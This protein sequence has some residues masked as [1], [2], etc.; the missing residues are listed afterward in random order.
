MSP[1]D[2]LP[3]L[4]DLAERAD[5]L[6]LERFRASDLRV[7][8]KPDRSLVTEADLA[9]EE[10]ARSVV[11]ERHPELGIFGEEHGEMVGDGLARLIIDPIDAT[12]NFA[13]GIPVFAT[14]LAIEEGDEVIAGLVSAPALA[15]RWWAA[16]GE[17][18]YRS[19]QRISVSATGKL[20]NAQIFY[21]SLGGY[22]AHRTPPGVVDVA[23]SGFR[24]RGF[25]D[26]WQHVLVAEGAG[27]VAIDPIVH[28]WDIAPLLVIVE[29]AGGRATT[30]SGERSV[31][32]GSLVSS[33]GV[34]HDEILALLAGDGGR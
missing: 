15:T 6:A 27:E 28:A 9:I 11:A 5:A 2:W 19:G 33:N 3:L 29:E 13:R 14:L 24:D 23:K 32:A 25:G 7:D 16:R 20:A 12:A 4:R 17:G 22:E 31:H 34:L 1:K 26:F 21:G 18:A 10:M 30:L 8:E